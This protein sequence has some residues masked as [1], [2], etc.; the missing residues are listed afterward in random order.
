M[1]AWALLVTALLTACTGSPPLSD[2]DL[3]NTARRKIETA[4]AREILKDLVTELPRLKGSIRAEFT[5]EKLAQFNRAVDLTAVT[6]SVNADYQLLRYLTDAEQA[7]WHSNDFSNLVSARSSL[8]VDLNTI[9]VDVMNELNRIDQTLAVLVQGKEFD[10]TDHMR[11]VRRNATY[12]EDSFQGRQ[13]YLDQLSEAMA[14][15][16]DQWQHLVKRYPGSQLELSGSETANS[17]FTYEN[18]TLTIDLANV[19]DLPGFE[20]SAI[21]VFYGFPGRSALNQHPGSIR[22]NLNLPGYS[23]GWSSYALDLV[24]NLDVSQTR[25]YLYFS[26]LLTSLALADLRINQDVWTTKQAREKILDSTPYSESRIGQM[27]KTVARYPGFYLSGFVGK[28]KFAALQ[29]RCVK[30]C[31]SGFHQKIIDIGPVPFEMLEDRL[32][33]DGMIR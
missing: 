3:D 13:R 32:V 16:H 1:R 31:G 21:A 20:Q 22:A 18:N 25:N 7:Y 4:I 28:Q 29:S 5:A 2:I 12:P 8:D 26:R 24:A 10:L 17:T 9:E 27:L 19:A 23:L 14:L 6:S 11:E 15:A 30:A 33:K